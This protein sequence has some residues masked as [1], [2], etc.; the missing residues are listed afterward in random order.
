M[1]DAAQQIADAYQA[2][3]N[4]I[5]QVSKPLKSDAGIATLL[6]SLNIPYPTTAVHIGRR[7]GQLPELIEAHNAA[8]RALEGVLTRYFKD[9]ERLPTNRP[10]LRIGGW[11]GV[12][13]GKKVD[14][15]DF[16]TEKIKRYDE[17]IEV[18][19]HQIDEKKAEN[20]G[21]ASFES[22]P[23]A[24]L[25]AKSTWIIQ[26]TYWLTVFP[27]RGAS[28]LFDLAQ[29]V[30]LILV[31]GRAKLFGR[32]PRD[33]REWTTPPAFDYPVYFSNHLLMLVVGLVYTPLA[34]LVP[35]FAA[36][37]FTVSFLVYKYQL[38][39]VSI[40]R[41]ETGGRLWRVCI[42]RVLFAL[43]MMQAVMLLTI[44]LQRGW[45][46]SIAVAPPVAF[47]IAFKLILSSKF[48]NAFDW[49]AQLLL[50]SAPRAGLRLN[51]QRLRF[52]P[53]E[54]E[55]AEVY[56]HQA[57]A[58]KHRLQK[59]FGHPSL[60]EPLMTP[61][62]HKS[63]QHLLPTIYN[64]RVGQ[65]HGAVDGKS[66]QQNTAGGLTFNMLEAH[67]LQYDR[68]AYL[69]QRDE[70]AM[71]VS[72]AF[73]GTKTEGPPDDYFAQRRANYLA[74]GTPGAGS[75]GATPADVDLPYELSRMPTKMSSESTDNLISYPPRYTSPVGGRG[76]HPNLSQ[77]S[78][79]SSFG[80]HHQ[81]VIASQQQQ[82]YPHPPNRQDSYESIVGPGGTRGPPGGAFHRQMPSQNS[83]E[84][85]GGA[86]S[87][88]GRVASPLGGDTRRRSYAPLS[89]DDDGKVD[90]RK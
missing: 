84:Y 39:Y 34:P 77:Q 24:H 9:P 58:R 31:W 85:D 57:D 11:L 12:C 68:T 1:S 50:L 69:R 44:G 61:M 71:T 21:F 46:D 33:I 3:L 70:D 53:S 17:R 74:H 40:S 54:S 78:F 8:V 63:V 73:A 22:V 6:S 90:F 47:V 89:L 75:P 36:A 81:E 25:V 80:G 59:R 41:V 35:L 4:K 29:V 10:T 72:T 18:T 86:S 20:Y 14:A 65:G 55:M 62:L 76:H 15:I 30:S 82:Y 49:Y 83:A 23:Y 38:M 48:D 64:G 42:N 60:H 56:L 45:M 52:I 16:L 51:F 67:D 26:S 87:P 19:R 66:V 88:P 43:I 2:R 27:L 7:V 13:G 5:T 28:A 32:T 37:A 79:D